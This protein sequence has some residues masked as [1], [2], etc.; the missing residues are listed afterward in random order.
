[1]EDSITLSPRENRALMRYQ[2]SD[3][4]IDPLTAYEKAGV[5]LVSITREEL[6][7]VKARDLHTTE[8]LLEKVS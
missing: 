8:Q 6:L 7:K 1:M 4:F 5:R 2:R 3:E